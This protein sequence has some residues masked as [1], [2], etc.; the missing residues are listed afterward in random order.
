MLLIFH[1]TYQFLDNY[2]YIKLIELQLLSYF[3]SR[4]AGSEYF[5]GERRVGS[6]Y[7]K[8]RITH[9]A[10]TLSEDI[11]HQYN[12]SNESIGSGHSKSLVQASKQKN[13]T[14]NNI[15][16]GSINNNTIPE[17]T[18]ELR[19]LKKPIN[20][21]KFADDRVILVSSKKVPYLVFSSLPYSKGQRSSW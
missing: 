19:Y 10:S 7:C 15:Q 12:S 21:H 2:L 11:K 13:K 6:L 5:L 9:Q 8:K 4:T 3:R 18:R 14:L 16:S 20:G 1:F 17:V